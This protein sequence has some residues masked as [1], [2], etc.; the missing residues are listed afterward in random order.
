M[1]FIL[2]FMV[3]TLMTIFFGAVAVWLAALAGSSKKHAP[4][5]EVTEDEDGEDFLP[6]YKPKRN[7]TMF[8]DCDE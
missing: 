3:G 4:V 5:K 2:G 8:G 7:R 6:K 1:D